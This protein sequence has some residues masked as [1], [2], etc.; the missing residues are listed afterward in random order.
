MYGLREIEP[1][2]KNQLLPTWEAGAT[3]MTRQ[4]I[5]DCLNCF[6]VNAEKEAGVSVQEG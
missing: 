6:R 4:S 3:Q 2:D 5:P 1:A